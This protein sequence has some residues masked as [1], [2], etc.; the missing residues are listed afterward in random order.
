ME[1]T[2]FMNGAKLNTDPEKYL[3]L[4]HAI[5]PFVNGLEE[6]SRR[7]FDSKVPETGAYDRIRGSDYVTAVD[8]ET[9]C[10]FFTCINAIPR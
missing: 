8:S 4:L 6:F 2:N 7:F 9:Q 1:L 10:I 5:T 3:K